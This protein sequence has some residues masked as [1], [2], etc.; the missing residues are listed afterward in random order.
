VGEREKGR[1]VRAK[2]LLL[3]PIDPKQKGGT[4]WRP[5]GRALASGPM[6]GDGWKLGQNGEGGKGN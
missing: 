4:T 1:G 2:R 5:A 6:L 3:P